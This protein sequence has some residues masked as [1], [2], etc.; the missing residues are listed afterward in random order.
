MISNIN[1]VIVVIISSVTIIVC[2]IG[3]VIASI[4]QNK[5]KKKYNEVKNIIKEKEGAIFK[6]KDGLTK[7]EINNIDN[8][9]NVDEL[10]KELYNIYLELENKVKSFD[11]N[12][13]NILTGHLKDFYVT[14]VENFKERK[15]AEVTDGIDLISYSITEYS[16]DKLKFRVVINCFSY[17]MINN[18]IVSGSNL[19][20]V[21]QIISLEYKKV[22]DKWLISSYEKL[23][24]K[25]LSV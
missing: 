5:Q 13:D 25:K 2:S 23:Y 6:I 11:I 12:F 3:I 9:V 16:K 18:E 10:M 15:F 14:K 24:E 19:E 17:K 21:E 4:F 20:K 7:E 22:E 8:V 1:N